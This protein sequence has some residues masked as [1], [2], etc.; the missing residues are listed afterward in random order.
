MRVRTG[1]AKPVTFMGQPIVRRLLAFLTQTFDPRR[2]RT[3]AWQSQVQFLRFLRLNSQLLFKDGETLSLRSDSGYFH[4][5]QRDS[6]SHDDEQQSQKK[7]DQVLFHNDDTAG[8]GLTVRCDS[9][10]R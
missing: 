9:S 2:F 8:P 6:D 5:A 3:H 4:H 10:A 7:F 1:I